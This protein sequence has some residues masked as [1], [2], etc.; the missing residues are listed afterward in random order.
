[1]PDETGVET[2]AE[3]GNNRSMGKKSCGQLLAKIF[4]AAYRGMVFWTVR[5]FRSQGLGRRAGRLVIALVALVGILYT[6]R[7]VVSRENSVY[8]QMNCWVNKQIEIA[9]SDHEATSNNTSQKKTLAKPKAAKPSQNEA[10]TGK[11]RG[12]IQVIDIPF[13]VA[14]IYGLELAFWFG[15]IVIFS[16]LLYFVLSDED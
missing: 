4:H 10:P 5:V 3:D 14:F 9:A 7:H 11:A 2:A 8:E 6:A 13:S 16:R 1:M 15:L 12:E